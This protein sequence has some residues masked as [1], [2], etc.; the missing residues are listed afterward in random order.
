MKT[1]LVKTRKFAKEE[2]RFY[3][4]T[5]EYSGEKGVCGIEITPYITVKT[6]EN[7]FGYDDTFI[8]SHMHK[9]GHYLNRGHVRWITNKIIEV[10]AKI[11]E[12]LPYS[13]D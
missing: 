1:T 5:P 2:Y 3:L 4:N 6:P 8:Y 9:S 10:C 7:D 13:V 12:S 11:A